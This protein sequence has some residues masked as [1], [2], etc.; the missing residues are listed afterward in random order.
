VLFFEKKNQKT[1]ALTRFHLAR[2]SLTGA[3]PKEQKFFASFF[4]KRTLLPAP[5]RKFKLTL[6]YVRLSLH[7]SKATRA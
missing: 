2:C 3:E 7:P 6:C 4:Q 1:F 5:D